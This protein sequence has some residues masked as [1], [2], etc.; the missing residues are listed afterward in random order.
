M[1]EVFYIH[2][3]LLDH[4]S[5]L[6]ETRGIL[7]KSLFDH[8]QLIQSRGCFVSTACGSEKIPDLW[9]TETFPEGNAMAPSPRA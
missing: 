3:C 2:S 7:V 5:I 8:L 4:I 9:E 1:H 6:C